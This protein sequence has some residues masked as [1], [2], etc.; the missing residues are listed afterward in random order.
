MV[1]TIIVHN[2]KKWI[3]LGQASR[4][5]SSTTSWQLPPRYGSSAEDSSSPPKVEEDEKDEKPKK[6]RGKKAQKDAD[7]APLTSGKKGNK[8]DDDDDESDDLDGLETVLDQDG[9]KNVN[10]KPASKTKES[11]KKRPAASRGSK[12][13][14]CIGRDVHVMNMYS[15]PTMVTSVIHA[16]L[17]FST[18]ETFLNTLLPPFRVIHGCN[19][20]RMSLSSLKL[21]GM[22]IKKL[23]LIHLESC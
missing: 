22:V 21:K 5:S 8:D 3:I 4:P 16:Y 10:R 23:Y 14:D 6:K 9:D 7:H 18:L 17:T 13:K 1:D 15:N 20:S 2:F 19:H 12:K 11:T